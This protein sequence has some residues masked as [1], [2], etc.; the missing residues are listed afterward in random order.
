MSRCLLVHGLLAR[1]VEKPA[2]RVHAVHEHRGTYRTVCSDQV[3][4]Q[5]KQQSDAM[6]RAQQSQPHA[7][8]TVSDWH[9]T[10]SAPKAQYPHSNPCQQTYHTNSFT[11]TQN[12]SH[13]LPKRSEVPWPAAQ[14]QL[15]NTAQQLHLQTLS[16]CSQC[17]PAHPVR[18]LLVAA[19]PKT[20]AVPPAAA[21]APAA[22]P[23]HAA[24][25]LCHR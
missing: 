15:Y 7:G 5:K 19:A 2:Q 8:P 25:T 10:S 12:T 13:T 21:A 24:N 16:P 17:N 1:S 18:Q 4:Y 22:A 11:G 3:C 6:H 23:I 14:N 20:V 9:P